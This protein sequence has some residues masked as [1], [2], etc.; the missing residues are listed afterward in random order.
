MQL[1]VITCC[2]DP[3][4]ILLINDLDSR[5]RSY[6]EL[7][8][9]L[10]GFSLRRSDRRYIAAQHSPVLH[11]DIKIAPKIWVAPGL[12]VLEAT[13]NQFTMYPRP[14]NIRTARVRNA[15]VTHTVASPVAT[16]G[17]ITFITDS[18]GTV[19]Y[20][21]GKNHAWRSWLPTLWG[22]D[23]VLYRLFI[24]ACQLCDTRERENALALYQDAAALALRTTCWGWTN[25]TLEAFVQRVLT[26]ELSGRRRVVSTTRFSELIDVA[27]A[28]LWRNVSEAARE[29]DRLG[30]QR[31]E[32]LEHLNPMNALKRS[33]AA[34]LDI[35]Q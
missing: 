1:Y 33:I 11:A 4:H 2:R 32:V 6:G 3:Q 23:P 24:E 18:C 9:K 10:V 29:S 15:N 35:Y 34:T 30:A 8:R 16:R 25:G 12:W 31:Y 28:V 21:A 5:A 20:F 14:R 27:I 19:N 7:R 17:S 26:R 13:C 22:Y